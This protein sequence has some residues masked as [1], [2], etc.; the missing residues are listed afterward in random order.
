MIS[1]KVT[2]VSKKLNDRA[3]LARSR[4]KS[5]S[6]GPFHGS[7]RTF[8]MLA[9]TIKVSFPN[10]TA[11]LLPWLISTVA[12]LSFAVFPLST[13]MVSALWIHCSGFTSSSPLFHS[14]FCAPH[15]SCMCPKQCKRGLQRLAARRRCWQP[16]SSPVRVTSKT[17][18][19]GPWVIMTS[20]LGKPGMGLSAI[21]LVFG[22]HWWDGL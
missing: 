8:M 9:L 20:M 2:Y 17:P 21:G 1:L 14:T 16:T 5:T 19:G 18:K 22:V 4:S 15:P 3:Q 10:S 11:V 12:A 7:F 6:H 13:C